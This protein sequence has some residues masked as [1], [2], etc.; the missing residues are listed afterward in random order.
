MA[1]ED[2]PGQVPPVLDPSHVGISSWAA[3][4]RAG[5]V[6]RSR[7]KADLSERTDFPGAGFR[8]PSDPPGP[9]GM[10]ALQAAV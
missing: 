6:Q 2:S 10:S 7:Y 4:G 8:A 9:G 1:V 3:L 5:F